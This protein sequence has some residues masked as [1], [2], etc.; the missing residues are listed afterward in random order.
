MIR[1][2]CEMRQIGVVADSDDD[3]D[4]LLKLIDEIIEDADDLGFDVYDDDYW[5][6]LLD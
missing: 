3:S 2:C 6:G 1:D 4:E 5:E